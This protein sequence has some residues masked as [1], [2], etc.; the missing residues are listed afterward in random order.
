MLQQGGT[1]AQGQMVYRAQ[2]M[3]AS[4]TNLLKNC[5]NSNSYIYLANL[6]LVSG[7]NEKSLPMGESWEQTHQDKMSYR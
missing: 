6:T 2:N 7:Q 5:K 3:Q 1:T 4:E